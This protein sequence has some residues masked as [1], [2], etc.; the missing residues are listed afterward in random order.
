MTSIGGGAVARACAKQTEVR[1][2]NFVVTVV[3]K[4]TW[5]GSILQCAG[6]S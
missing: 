2:G 5:Q 4:V 6:E 3:V 1:V